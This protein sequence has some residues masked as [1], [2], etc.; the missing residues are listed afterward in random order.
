MSAEENFKIFE[1]FFDSLVKNTIELDLEFKV[2]TV[3]SL[4]H[5][6]IVLDDQLLLDS[7]YQ[8]GCY[9]FAKNIK[10]NKGPHILTLSM[11]GKTSHDTLIEN[12]SIVKDKFIRFN[13]FYL[14]NYDLV[15]DYSLR[16]H[17]VYTDLITKQCKEVKLGFWSNA[18]LTINFDS[19]IEIFFNGH[20]QRVLHKSLEFRQKHEELLNSIKL[21]IIKNVDKLVK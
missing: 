18:Q 9:S 19:P 15:N 8:P 17:F 21:E 20:G 5:F 6:Q 11:T 3:K 16:K 7:D 1:T 2:D 14:N 12:G 4:C 13:K 10:V